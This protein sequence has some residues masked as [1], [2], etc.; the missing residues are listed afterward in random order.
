LALAT[1]NSVLAST[2]VSNAVSRRF[3][4]TT[5]ASGNSRLRIA[6]TAPSFSNS[7]PLLATITG[8]HT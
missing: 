1:V 5:A 7:S 2:P 4:V 3:G 8:S 6:V